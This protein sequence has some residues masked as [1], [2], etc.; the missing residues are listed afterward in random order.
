MLGRIASCYENTALRTAV[1]A[2]VVLAAL[3]WVT[4]MT[5]RT[6]V[7]LVVLLAAM[8]VLDVVDAEYDLPDGTNGLG[9]GTAVFVAG[10]YVA[11]IDPSPRVGGLLALAGLWFAFDGATTVRYAPSRTKH[12]YVSDLDDDGSGEV[13]L[14][15]QTLNVVYQGLRDAAEPKTA[16]ALAADLDLTDS[17]VESAL[18]YLETRGRVERIEGRYRATPPRWGRLTPVVRFLVWLPRRLLRPFHRLAV[19]E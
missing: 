5:L 7:P 10:A 17:R 2:V 14:R 11:V 9:Y 19:R 15:M 6:A 16:T 8:T 12:E 4:E 1:G 3:V 13:L 18:G